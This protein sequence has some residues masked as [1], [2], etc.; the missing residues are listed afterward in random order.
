MTT[1]RKCAKCGGTKYIIVDDVATICSCYSR[2]LTKR[3]LDIDLGK[4]NLPLDIVNYD[5]NSY[6]GTKSKESV[7]K[8]K[9]YAAG[10]DEKFKS[11]SLYLYSPLNGTQKTTLAKFIGRELTS[12]GKSVYFIV[13]GDLLKILSEQSYEE[14]Y[15][16]KVNELLQKD[17]LIIDDAFD[18]NK[19]TVYKS[20]WQ[21]SFLDTFLRKRL[22][23]LKK[24]II[25]TSNISFDNIGLSFPPSIQALV[26]RN[27]AEISLMDVYDGKA[28]NEEELFN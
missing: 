19:A 26:K 15:Q 24:A 10:F 20:G 25:F 4:A 12:Q 28:F 3:K 11:I 1:R 5:I 7:E 22:E 13:M 16:S 18:K 9:T 27:S 14:G 8:I 21:F 6:V 17:L 2:F 23:V